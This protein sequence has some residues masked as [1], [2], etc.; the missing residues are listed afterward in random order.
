MYFYTDDV[1]FAYVPRN[2]DGPEYLYF[3]LN[4]HC[5]SYK[6]M[7]TTKPLTGTIT[8]SQAK[9]LNVD[10][11]SNRISKLAYT[12]HGVEGTCH[13]WTRL[14]QVS[15]K[16]NLNHVTFTHFGS[17]QSVPMVSYQFAGIGEINRN[18]WGAMDKNNIIKDSH[19]MI[20]NPP[21]GFCV[22]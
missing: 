2:D 11:R 10:L 14:D 17:D 13:V 7:F 9:Q 1:K 8:R 4:D 21:D 16:V 19:G 22:F 18:K 3:A 5:L 15:D 6:S 12:V 20:L